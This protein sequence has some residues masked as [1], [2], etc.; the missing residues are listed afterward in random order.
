MTRKV[1]LIGLMLL[2]C[3]SFSNLVAAQSPGKTPPA[4]LLVTKVVASGLEGSNPTLAIEGKGFTPQASTNPS[5]YMGM[6]GGN[7][8]PLA[9]NSSSDTVIYVSLTPQSSAPGTYLV[10]VSRGSSTTDV[11]STVVTL[12]AM[13]PKGPAGPAGNAGATGPQGPSGPQ[14]TQGLPGAT[15]PQGPS[16]SQGTQG[17]A[18]ATG[19]QGPGGATG[20]QGPTGPQGQQGFPGSQGLQ[21]PTG[22]QGPQGGGTWK[23][24]AVWDQAVDGSVPQK[25][26]K[27][28]DGAG[29]ILLVAQG[30]TKST[31]GR[32]FV[33]VSVNNGNNYFN[34]NGDYLVAGDNGVATNTFVIGTFE[35]LTTAAGVTGWVQ[36][37]GAGLPGIRIGRFSDTSTA[38]QRYF[39]G[40]TSPI[41]AVKVFP[42]N[43]G[44]LTGGKIYCYTRS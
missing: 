17:V 31:S 11:Y 32:L 18:G 28:L 8:I 21:G 24:A 3:I 37:E 33:Q 16:G 39:V 10:V 27:N 41:N 22:P 12:G 40:S 7:L 5:V 35:S 43:G 34:T 26:F 13:G 14:G 20:S 23:L 38:A 6:A 9:V 2:F 30:V 19:P 4:Q 15:G 1:A 44:N 36:I 29:D 25:E 42:N